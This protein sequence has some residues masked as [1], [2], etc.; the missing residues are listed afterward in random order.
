MADRVHRKRGADLG[1]RVEEE[2][3]AEVKCGQRREIL[4]G[5]L[6]VAELV[7]RVE[8]VCATTGDSQ[9]DPQT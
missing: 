2:S 5:R 1:E 3:S 8:P 7:D 4:A 9:R 6:V